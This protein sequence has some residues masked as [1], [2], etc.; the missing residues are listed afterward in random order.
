MVDSGY[1]HT[2]DQMLIGFWNG[3]TILYSKN[4]CRN[5]FQPTIGGKKPTQN[6]FNADSYTLVL[7]GKL[8]VHQHKINWLQFFFDFFPVDTHTVC[9]AENEFPISIYENS[10]SIFKKKKSTNFFLFLIYKFLIVQHLTLSPNDMHNNWY[11]T[12]LKTNHSFVL[13]WVCIPKP[14]QCNAKSKPKR[15]TRT[16]KYTINHL[17]LSYIVLNA[18]RSAIKSITFCYSSKNPPSETQTALAMIFIWYLDICLLSFAYRTKL[19]RL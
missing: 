14:D 6:G 2:F 11:P 8:V 1:A 17:L 12:W 13:V 7:L 3:Q 15:D 18:I 10:Q 9:W 16:R 5:G 19:M 4:L